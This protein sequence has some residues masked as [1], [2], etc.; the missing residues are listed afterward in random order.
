MR[1]GVPRVPGEAVKTEVSNFSSS[2]DVAQFLPV[3]DFSVTRS[4]RGKEE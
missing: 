2:G 3:R 4:L 1:F